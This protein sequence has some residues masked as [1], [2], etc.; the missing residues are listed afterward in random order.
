MACGDLLY[1]ETDDGAVR[2]DA[3]SALFIRGKTKLV[4]DDHSYMLYATP[5]GVGAVSTHDSSTT[6]YS[7]SMQFHSLRAPCEVKPGNA[8]GMALSC[9]D[10]RVVITSSDIHH[11]AEHHPGAA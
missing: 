11:L 4:M 6:L 10:S 1:L 5:S 9:A 3:H 2:T 7:A 8:T